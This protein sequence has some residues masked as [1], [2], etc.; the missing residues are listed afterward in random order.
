MNTKSMVFRRSFAASVVLLTGCHG[1]HE[2]AADIRPVRTTLVGTGQYSDNLTYTGE[3]RARHESDLGFQVSG[4][5]IARPA[6]GGA[7]GTAGAVFGPVRPTDEKR[8]GEGG[9]RS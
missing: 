4:K 7:A 5:L 1:K 9:A 8:G 3:I 2:P 6:E